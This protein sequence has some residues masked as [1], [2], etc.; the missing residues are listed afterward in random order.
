MAE[1][2]L[3]NVRKAYGKKVVYANL[4]L[5]IDD[6]ECFTLLGPSGCGKTVLLRMA[7]G[8]EQPDAGTITVGGVT[9]SSPSER[10]FVPPDERSLGVV[11][12]DTP[13]GPT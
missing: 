6:G 7:A 10:I 3:E 9:L 4:N 1:V 5:T 2:R 13:S 12:Q 8:F 11:F